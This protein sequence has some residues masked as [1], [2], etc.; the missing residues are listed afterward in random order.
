MS[1]I[2][3]KWGNPTGLFAL[4]GLLFAG[5]LPANVA[6]AADEEVA[7]EEVVVTGSRIKRTN[8][9][10][11][12]QLH[13]MDRTE[14]DA[15]GVQT[16]ADV[17]R[18][19]PLNIYGSFNER[20]GSSAQSNANI[21]LR[22]LGSD[23][24]LVMVNGRRMTGSPAQGASTVN[25][26]MLPMTAI[27]RMD[28]LADGGSAVYGSDAVAGVVNLQMRE[29]FE[30]LEIQVSGGNRKEDSGTEE[31]LSLIAGARGDKTS[32]TFVAEYNKRS[33][34]FDADRDYTAPWIVDNGD[35]RTDTYIDTDGISY[36]GKT[37]QLTDPNTDHYDIQAANDC[38]TDGGFYGVMGAL[39]FGEAD[40]TLCTYGYAGISANKAGLDKLSTY[41][42]LTHEV[43]GAVE[44]FATALVSRV[45]SFGRYAPPA[46]AWPN[47]P[48]DYKDVPYDIDALIADGTITN[49]YVLKGFYRWTNIGPR[50]G[51]ITDSLFDFV[52]GFRGDISDNVSYEVYSQRSKYDSKD[53]GKYFLS[54]PGLDYVLNEGLDP[55]SAEGAGAMSALPIQDNLTSMQKTYGQ[56]QFGIGDFFGS[57]EALAL[58][59]GELIALNYVN[60]YDR[61]S[62]N[63]FVGGSAGNS[64]SGDRDVSAIFAE[65]LVPIHES[66]EVNGAIRYDDYSDFGSNVSPSL[67]ATYELTPTIGLRAR[68][69]QGFRA[70]GLDQLYGPETFSA[71]DATD[72]KTCADQGTAVEDC[73]ERQFDTYY[74]TNSTLDAEDSKTF[75]V[76]GNW[77]VGEFFDLDLGY[78]QVKVDNVIQ[79]SSTQDVF[80][81]EAAGITL[82]SNTGTYVDRTGALPVVYSSY[83]NEGELNATGVDF[84]VSG[85]FETDGF[86]SFS[87]DF[88]W[89]HSLKYEQAAFYRGPIQETKGFWLQPEDRMQAVLGWDFRQHKV[90]LVVDYIG[91]HSEADFV[92]VKEN[93]VAVLETSDKE[94]DSWTTMNLSYT[95]DAEQYGTLKVGARNLTNEEPVFDKSGKFARDHYDLYDNTGRVIYFEYKLVMD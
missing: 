88:L 9:E 36:Y 28:I 6:V 70:P 15:I 11:G 87:G 20:S 41:A 47:M 12:A 55:F 10:T 51:E 56:V 94:L 90:T 65:L 59:G 68:W 52:A 53:L 74:S 75:S 54:Y 79:Q 21:D 67:S 48:A 14:I 45:E 46:A 33:P 42:S 1:K 35:G 34:I 30:G 31:G 49:D 38:P 58:I 32:I 26:N 17:L 95:Y 44:F 7:I 29:D 24:T 2:E 92:T 50:D 25:I 83:V 60:E 43:S 73:P 76:G 77:R 71:E 61:G 93:G 16:I 8:F 23:R 19:S 89:S 80:Y 5:L 22:G 39:A 18:S 57:G 72:Y 37:I 91:P 40:G 64:S 78:W 13:S 62:E 4:V 81:A 69:S 85:L 84:N 27:E 66:L 86:G 82:D 63:G 3:S